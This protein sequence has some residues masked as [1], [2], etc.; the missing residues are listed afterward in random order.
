MPMIVPEM[1]PHNPYLCPQDPYLTVS[2]T[3]DP[4]LTV[5][6]TQRNDQLFAI[7]S[8]LKFHIQMLAKRY[9]TIIPFT[10]I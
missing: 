10:P 3:Q 7:I 9:L 5:S 8:L 1:S 6:N 2:N 4:H